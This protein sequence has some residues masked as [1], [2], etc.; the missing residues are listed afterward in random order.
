MQQVLKE[1]SK[2]LCHLFVHILSL[3]E[4]INKKIW[5]P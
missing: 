4:E 5:E 3:L 2:R 1:E